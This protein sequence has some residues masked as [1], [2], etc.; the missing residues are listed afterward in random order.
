M[1]FKTELNENLK[2][3]TLLTMDNGKPMT[4]YSYYIIL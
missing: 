1:C 2:S 4:L 3:I